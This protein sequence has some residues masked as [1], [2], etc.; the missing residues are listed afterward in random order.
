[1]LQRTATRNNRKKLDNRN[2]NELREAT[3][4]N[5]SARKGVKPGERELC[6]LHHAGILFEIAFAVKEI[7]NT[8]LDWET[9]TPQSGQWTFVREQSEMWSG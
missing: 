8:E 7:D 3:K 2:N 4:V 1:M 6:A 5:F 9:W